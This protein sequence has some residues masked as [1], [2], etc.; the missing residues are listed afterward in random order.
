MYTQYDVKRYVSKDEQDE[1]NEMLGCLGNYVV[2]DMNRRSLSCDKKAN[3][4]ISSGI[5]EVRL[6]LD[7]S[8][9]IDKERIMQRN[10]E[11][12]KRLYEFFSE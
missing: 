4:Y 8:I 2:L 3:Y 11:I 1:Y 7:G 6:L 9:R 12:K 5:Q 10:E